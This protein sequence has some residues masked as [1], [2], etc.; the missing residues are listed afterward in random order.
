MPGGAAAAPA[1]HPPPEL[2]LPAPPPRPHS[3][4]TVA[5]PQGWARHQPPAP[6]PLQ[7]TLPRTLLHPGRSLIMVPF[8]RYGN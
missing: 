1:T 8:S 7:A 5:S 4:D 6:A 3:G 2:A